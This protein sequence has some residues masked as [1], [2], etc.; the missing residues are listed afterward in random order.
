[1]ILDSNHNSFLGKTNLENAQVDEVVDAVT[2]RLNLAVP[3]YVR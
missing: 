1:M 3:I 2:V